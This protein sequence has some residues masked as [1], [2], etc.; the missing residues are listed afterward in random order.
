MK[1]LAIDTSTDYLSLAVTD[2]GK[3]LGRFHRRIGRNHSSMLIPMIDSLLKK[4]RLKLKDIGGFVVSIGPGSFTG[5][6][7]G[8]ATVKGLALATGKPIVAVPTLDAVARNA[9]RF[10]GAICPVL[11]ARK[12]K[13][14]ACI[15]ESDG[16]VIKRRSKYLLVS[17]Q[18]LLEKIKRYDKIFFLGDGTA[19]LGKK[20]GKADWYPRAEVAARLGLEDFKKRKFVKAEDLEP[21]YIYSKECD[22]IG[23]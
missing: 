21:L 13:L 14:Y 3:I 19:L 10:K 17:A 16:K 8:V 5:L 6:R 23:K 4:A 20:A 18:D 2:G 1:I 12:N 7:I 15:Y 11:D 9:G 22:I